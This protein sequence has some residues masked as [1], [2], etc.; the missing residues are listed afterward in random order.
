M[1]ST[2]AQQWSIALFI[3]VYHLKFTHYVSFEDLN[4]E[5]LIH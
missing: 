1:V 5:L 3:S 2:S 4:T